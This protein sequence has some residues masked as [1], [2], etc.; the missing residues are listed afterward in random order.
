VS[1]TRPAEEGANAHSE[2]DGASG[3]IGVFGVVFASWAFASNLPRRSADIET[4]RRYQSAPTEAN[5]QFWLQERQK[6]QNEVTWRKYAVV[7]LAFGNVFLIVWIARRKPGDASEAI[8][9]VPHVGP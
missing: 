3:D 2:K 7:V 4:F 8:G 9:A 6:T 5:K 1:E